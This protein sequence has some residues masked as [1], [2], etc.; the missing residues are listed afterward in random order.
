MMSQ[1]STSTTI[2]RIEPAGP[3]VIPRPTYA[4]AGLAMG[5]MML[6]WGIMTHW[7]MSL[8]GVLLMGW[9]LW[10]WINE[11]RNDAKDT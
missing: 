1:Q 4:P 3:T 2:K 6:F 11:I 8:A 5:I 9:A 10:T 7:T